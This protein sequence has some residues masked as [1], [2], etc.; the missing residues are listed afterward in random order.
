MVRIGIYERGDS[1]EAW[2]SQTYQKQEDIE[3]FRYLRFF[4]EAWHLAEPV[5]NDIK[6]SQKG[7]KL[8]LCSSVLPDSCNEEG[9]KVEDAK[10]EEWNNKERDAHLLINCSFEGGSS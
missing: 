1:E 5:K 4:R 2:S 6:L 7:K 3:D 8:S 9:Y 10:G